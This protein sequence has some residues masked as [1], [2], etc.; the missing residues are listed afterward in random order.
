M[1]SAGSLQDHDVHIWRVLLDDP[2]WDDYA[3]V[4]NDAERAKAARYRTQ[5]LQQRNRRCRSALRVILARYVAAGAA[6]LVFQYGQYGKPELQDRP[7]HFNVSHSGDVALLAVAKQALGVDLEDTGKERSDL[8]GLIDMVCHPS[9]QV[10]LAQLTDANKVTQFYQLWTQKEAYCKMLGLGLQQSLPALYF[11]PV[12]GTTGNQVAQVCAEDHLP[13]VP[14]VLYR[15]DAPGE[16]SASLC[17][18]LAEAR[19]TYFTA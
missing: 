5:T 13:P 14:S 17:I 9:E 1:N 12:P 8:D 10:A 3:S 16:F 18:A 7:V 6:D 11:E 19:I 15:L 4:L 2:K